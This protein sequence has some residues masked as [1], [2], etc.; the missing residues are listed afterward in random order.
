[1]TRTTPLR[2]IILHLSHMRLMLARTFMIRSAYQKT[3]ATGLA[4]RA[5]WPPSPR[6]NPRTDKRPKRANDPPEREGG[7]GTIARWATTVCAAREVFSRWRGL[8]EARR[9]FVADPFFI[10][11]CPCAKYGRGNRYECFN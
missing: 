3:N 9:W 1:M 11:E 8:V 2:L 5:R 4:R 6:A 10:V 7:S